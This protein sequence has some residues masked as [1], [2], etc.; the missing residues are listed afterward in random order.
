MKK[1]MPGQALVGTNDISTFDFLKDFCSK[2]ITKFSYHELE[3]WRLNTLLNWIFNLY[4]YI[5]ITNQ[6]QLS[7]KKQTL[8]LLLV[9]AMVP[10]SMMAQSL[11]KV[12]GRVLDEFG[13][14][15]LGAVVRVAGTDIVTTTDYDGN[16]E[17]DGVASDAT[18]TCSYLGMTTENVKV[19]GGTMNISR[20]RMT[21]RAFLGLRS[22]FSGSYAMPSSSLR[23]LRYRRVMTIK[24]PHELTAKN[25]LKTY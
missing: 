15:L 12:K 24:V 18:L 25:M 2:S 3:N 22:Y 5:L 23:N 21:W 11:G 10:V 16:Y 8:A 1:W 13:E 6:I 14:P 9:L 20:V 7:M 17:L 4:I 19:K